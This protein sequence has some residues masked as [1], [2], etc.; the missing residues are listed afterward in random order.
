MNAT[1]RGA[2]ARGLVL[3]GNL[4][5]AVDRRTLE[6]VDRRRRTARIKGRG[7]LV[8]RM[9][10]AADLVGLT[11]AF[12]ASE[13]FLGLRT[14]S[15]DHLTLQAEVGLFV[16]TLPAWIVVAKLYG[17]YDSDEE[18]T[19][20]STV[21]DIVG[22]FHMVTVGAWLFFAGAWVTKLAD[23][24]LPK[25]LLFW[26]LAI[27]LVTMGRASARAISR[28]QMAYLQNTVIVGAGDVGQTIARKLLQHPEYGINLVGFVDAAPKE[29]RDDLDHLTLLGPPEHLPAIVR[30]FDVERVIVAFSGDTHEQTL[31]LLRCL[32]EFDVQVDIVP[33]LFELVS[34]GVGIHTVEGLPLV[35]LPPSYLSR[36]SRFLKRAMDLVLAAAGLV[37][38]APVF[39]LLALLIK[40]DSP[41]S[42]FFRQVR[43]GAGEKTFRIFK[44][45]TMVADADERKG[46]LAHLNKHTQNGGDGRMFKIAKDPRTTRIGR[47]LRR[48]SL[49]ELPQLINVLRGEMSLVGPRPLILDEDRHVVEWARKRLDLKP[50]I[51]GLWQ[52]LGRSEIPLEEMV[53]LDYLYVTTWSLWRDC[54]LLGRTIPFVVRGNGAAY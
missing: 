22:V 31:G 28:R 4:A 29:R 40:L 14:S 5:E 9:L 50:G 2:L 3:Y 8:R 49:D 32:K 11:L 45:R 18:R 12:V 35:G 38:L 46:E 16:A 54:R 33:R 37:V 1:E 39:A 48:F 47:L 23:P 41:G 15:I 7:W 27:G 51:T 26:T 25:L 44:F 34:P 24:K 13:F 21:D 6:I 53:R 17:L 36:S 10:L 42:V 43:M 30:L 20:H 52:S 19:D